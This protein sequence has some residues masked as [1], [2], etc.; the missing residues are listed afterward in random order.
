MARFIPDACW[1]GLLAACAAV[2]TQAPGAPLVPTVSAAAASPMATSGHQ[3]PITV[4]AASS[5]VDY[6]TNTVVFTQV[7]ISQGAMRVQADHAH[8]SGLNFANSR[9]TFDGHVRI[10]AEPRGS[11]RSD[12]AVVEFRDNRILRATASGKPAEF[13]QPRSDAQQQMARGHAEEIVYD[14]GEGTV[15]LSKDAWLSDGTNEISGPLLVYNIRAQ[16]VQAATAP[17]SDQRVHITIQPQN[18]PAAPGGKPHT[19]PGKPPPPNPRS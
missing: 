2:V 8:A 18:V 1:R 10:D 13:E 17:G 11:L 6:K 4:D 14:V 15:R 7:V 5:E 9:W 3:L 19:E 12:Q 16:R